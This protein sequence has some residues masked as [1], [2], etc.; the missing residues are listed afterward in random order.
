MEKKKLSSDDFEFIAL[1][2]EGSYGQVVLVEKKNDPSLKKYAL[3]M[4]DKN[5]L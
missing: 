4:I 3:K 1:L 2:G 5:F